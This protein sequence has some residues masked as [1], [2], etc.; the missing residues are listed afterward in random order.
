MLLI[1]HFLYQVLYYSNIKSTILIL[2]SSN[3]LT[4]V[5]TENKGVMVYL[6]PDL[7]K[8]IEQ[9]CTDNNITR[10]NKDGAIFPSLGTGIIQY[11]KSQLLGTTANMPPSI[12][13]SK[14][15]TKDDV[16]E[17]IAQSNTSG[18]P[19]N[20][21]TREDAIDLIQESIT[22][23]I[24]SDR[25][26]RSDVVEI[27]RVQI[28]AALAPSENRLNAIVSTNTIDLTTPEARA[29]DRIESSISL[30]PTTKKPKPEDEPTWV[31]DDNRRYYRKLIDNPEL[32]AK[33]TDAIDRNPD[34]NIDLARSFVDL[35]FHK[36]DGTP[37]G[38]SPTSRIKSVVK[39]LNTP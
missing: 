1:H 22:N 11:L 14:G 7:E 4:K 29:I 31:N 26:T 34:S 16:L 19:S 38:T 30:T 5:A 3:G 8:V 17:L 18:I 9:Y 20:L 24:P 25:L 21:L 37:L 15:L 33:V 2:D 13:A 10:K 32:L 6:P 27:I 23:N 28:E 35:G 12:L 39:H 36:Q